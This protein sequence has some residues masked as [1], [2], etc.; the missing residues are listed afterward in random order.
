M[1]LLNQGQVGSSAKSKVKKLPALVPLSERSTKRGALQGR[2]G[3]RSPGRTGLS[4]G[5]LKCW[6]WQGDV[7]KV[8]CH[9]LVPDYI[10]SCSCQAEPGWSV[11]QGRALAPCNGE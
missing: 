9:Q 10:L 7:A 6:C 8:S 11:A 4:W 1:L 2:K 5:Q 3:S